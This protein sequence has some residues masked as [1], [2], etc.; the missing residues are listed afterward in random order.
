MKKFILNETDTSIFDS[1]VGYEVGYVENRE[2]DV[3]VR[4]DKR[5]E[6]VI[7]SR[8]LLLGDESIFI[9]R[10]YVLDI[11]PKDKEANNEVSI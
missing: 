3:M 4:F 9:S 8:E 5:V 2:T 6:N 11:L 1:L 10:D 7:I